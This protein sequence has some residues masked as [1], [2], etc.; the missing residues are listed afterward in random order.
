MEDIVVKFKKM[1]N[2]TDDIAKYL[3]LEPSK[4]L[5]MHSTSFN[6]SDE[7][8]I[9]RR[10]IN[11]GR[12]I[13]AEP[14]SY[15]SSNKNGSKTAIAYFNDDLLKKFDELGI[16][17]YNNII[18]VSDVNSVDYPNNSVSSLL[19]QKV[20]KDEKFKNSILGTTIV[21]CYLSKEDEETAR[22]INGKVLMDRKL[23]EKFNS[24]Y[25]F[26][27]MA[28]KYGFSVPLGV[29]VKGLNE[30]EEKLK[31]LD[32]KNN[33]IN[34]LWIKLE[35]QS[36]GTGN[37]KIDNNNE[38]KVD[39]IKEKINNV[40]SQIF[41]KD[42]IDNE[43]QFIIETDINI[44]GFEEV[45]NIG[46]EA[47]ITE[48]RV[49]VL[50][51]VEQETKNGKYLGSKIDE[52]TDKYMN[53]A[54]KCAIKSFKAVS[55]E[56]Y[57]GF[58]TIDVLVTKN[59]ETGEIICFNID[60]NAR[61]SSGTM[62]LKN[63]HE[64]EAHNN[65]KMYGIS[66]TYLMPKTENTIKTMLDLLGED[67]YNYNGDYTG[68]IPALINDLNEL[69]ENRHYLKTVVVDFSYEAAKEKYNRFKNKV[70]KFIKE[71]NI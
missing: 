58:M 67:L 55:I 61:F 15:S 39:E 25:D 63:I 44:E 53:E 71:N 17:D 57:I 22:I 48:G 62:L 51:G 36:S 46:V 42:Y 69:K 11:K 40:S 31:K 70:K 41:D 8:N 47:V 54:I 32:E 3:E 35:S 28:E 29:C 27:L 9:K 52:S 37:I 56:G 6:E 49:T 60:P 4:T 2:G 13:F 64:S 65:K 34:N 12:M 66:F 16:I 10:A 33:N 38:N 1:P 14:L 24:K 59:K 45:A 23:Q 68:I 18:K 7:E 19:N 30:L 21:S 5:F 26:R 20:K 43:M 50:G